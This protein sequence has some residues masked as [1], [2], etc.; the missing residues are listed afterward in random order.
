MLIQARQ[1]LGAEAEEN[2]KYVFVQTQG[3]EMKNS[4]G[5][6]HLL[7]GNGGSLNT[8][9]VDAGLLQKHRVHYL[10]L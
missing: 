6:I 7:A 4:I 3:R 1:W 10:D 9:V 8:W 2:Y 5:V